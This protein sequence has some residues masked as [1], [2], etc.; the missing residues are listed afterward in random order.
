M[1]FTLVELVVVVAIISILTAI[2]L[3]ALERARTSARR[4]SCQSNLKQWGLVFKMYGSEAKGMKYPPL[5]LANM[6]PLAEAYLKLA[7]AA[8]P[9][10]AAIYPEY[11]ADFRI[12]ICPSDLR[13]TA[14]E[15]TEPI[16]WNGNTQPM[17]AMKPEEIDATYAYL[18]WTIDKAKKPA[19]A[20]SFSAMALLTGAV[21]GDPWVSAQFGAA[22]DG[23]IEE[24]P[25]AASGLA[26]REPVA[27]QAAL[28]VMDGD[29]TVP[30]AWKDQGAGNGGGNTIHRLGVGVERFTIT[31]LNDPASSAM[32][33]SNLFVMFDTMG[34]GRHATYFNHVPGGCNVLFMDGHVAWVQ[35]APADV[36]SLDDAARVE[37]AMKDGI[38]PVLPTMASLVSAFGN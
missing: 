2:L 32:A 34:A 9:A 8:G 17:L 23:L 19:R 38:D 15:V 5:Q 33:Q 35:Y 25:A 30:K 28:G 37:A 29:A 22:I 12:T 4:S 36:E 11:L 14:A 27:L 16:T 3:P 1:G 20:S 21:S 24:H 7:A 18:S 10:V 6:N 31:D 26:S 13:Y